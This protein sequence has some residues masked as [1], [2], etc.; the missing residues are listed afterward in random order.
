MSSWIIFSSMHVS[1]GFDWCGHRLSWGSTSSH[2]HAEFS[3]CGVSVDLA[4]AAGSVYFFLENAPNMWEACILLLLLLILLHISKVSFFSSFCFP[5]RGNNSF[6]FFFYL[7]LVWQAAPALTETNSGT[8]AQRV[9]CYVCGRQT[10]SET[11]PSFL[12]QGSV[13]TEDF[14]ACACPNGTRRQANGHK[15][16]HRC[17][18]CAPCFLLLSIPAF[19]HLRWL[20]F[21]SLS[22]LF[23]FAHHFCHSNCLVF[24][25]PYCMCVELFQRGRIKE[26]WGQ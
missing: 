18:C 19:T 21:P 26:K 5:C 22:A 15:H 10:K 13:V 2:I 8:A 3:V 11:D 1:H 20:H 17:L 9:P 16:T 6:L 25:A 23:L 14:D 7:W 24:E 12:H 4:P